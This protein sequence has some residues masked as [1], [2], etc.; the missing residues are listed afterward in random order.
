MAEENPDQHDKNA[1]APPQPLHGWRW[2]GL[3]RRQGRWLRIVP[4]RWGWVLLVVVGGLAGML[5]FAE[6]SMQP[7]FCRSCHIMEPYYQAWHTSTHKDVA[8]VLCHFE[9]GI[10][11]TLKGKWEAS[12]QGVKYITNTYGSKPH[13]EV[14]DSSC[15]REECHSKRLL[16]GKV[17]WPIQ[18]QR[19]TEITIKFDHTPHLSELRRGKELRCVSCH[20]QI[21]Q[22]QHL[23]VT[24]DTCF[25]CHFKG[26]EHG[27]DDQTL[28]GCKSCHDAPASEIK[29]T[30][31]IFK[32]EDY[33][34]RGV[35]CENCHVDTVSGDGAVPKQ[36][37]WTC[38]NK[39]T[40]IARYGETSFMHKTHITDNKVEC[41]SCHVQI[42]HHLTAGLAASGG[43]MAG[44]DPHA[45][46]EKSTCA[47]CHDLTHN[48][49][50]NIYSGTGGRGVPDM[51]SP[52]FNAQVDCVACHK[53][54]EFTRDIAEVTGQTYIA[55]QASCDY[56]HEGRYTGVLDEWRATIAEHLAFA[57]Q[58]QQLASA[59]LSVAVIPPDQQLKLQRLLDDSDHNIRLVKLG[60]GVHNVT[61]ATAL[62]NVAI[63]NYNKILNTLK[64]VPRIEPT[65]SE[66]QP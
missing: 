14:R 22:G 46:A 60:H 37:C 62:L 35:T 38:H 30:T 63:E 31:G 21:V 56:C 59:D 20:S 53:Q 13:A 29:L 2:V 8:C 27:R 64:P 11:N 66:P 5:G 41:S 44:P 9:P 40:Q 45:G 65:V 3:R 4:S 26:F 17:D 42:V 10:E 58:Q 15:M 39:P 16:E 36:L 34:D 24:L 18:T 7:D 57:Q 28:G 61:Y 54:R 55:A 1:P 32:H 49:P 6:Y 47:Q 33:I 23:V 19:G 25:L 51:P 48:G 43:L 50:A 52:M 12:S